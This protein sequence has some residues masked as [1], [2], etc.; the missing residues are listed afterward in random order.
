MYPNDFNQSK[1]VKSDNRINETR[2]E[3]S[4]TETSSNITITVKRSYGF[5]QHYLIGFVRFHHALIGE[6][7]EAFSD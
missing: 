3:I 7:L 5:L 6:V 4:T 1:G 2:E